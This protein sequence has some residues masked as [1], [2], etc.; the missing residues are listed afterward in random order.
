MK[1]GSRL[2]YFA[3]IYQ[4]F[5]TLKKNWV[6]SVAN[7]FVWL[8]FILTV[9]LLI[10]KWNDLPPLVPLLYSKSWGPERLVQP[11]WLLVLPFGSLFWYLITIIVSSHESAKYLIFIQMLFLSSFI[12]SLISFVCLVRIIF[13]VT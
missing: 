8:F 9:I 12:V 5:I 3:N 10:L 13:L 2:S 11:L 1:V 4:T 6:I 7:R